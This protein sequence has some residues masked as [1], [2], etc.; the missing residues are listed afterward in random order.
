M[1]LRDDFVLSVT[2]E[3]KLLE[4][5][6]DEGLKISFETSTSLASFWI[7]VKAEYPEL[8]GT[9][10]KTLLPFPSTYL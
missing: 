1:P 8:S 9:A 4:L 10:L 5:A 3:D 2:M 7:K 6:A